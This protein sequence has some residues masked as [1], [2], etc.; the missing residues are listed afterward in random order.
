MYKTTEHIFVIRF[1]D[2]TTLDEVINYG[3]VI[4][5]QK[6]MVLNYDHLNILADTTL[7]LSDVVGEIKSVQGYGLKNT[8]IVSPVLIRFLI[9]PGIQVYLSLLDDAAAV[10]K[11]LLNSGDGIRSVMVVTSL[12]P[13]KIGDHLHLSSTA[14]TKFYFGNKLPAIADF[15]KSF[16]GAETED[17]PNLNAETV[18]TSKQLSSVGDLNM[19]LSNSTGQD[20]YFACK[21]RIVEVV[22][23]NGWY[24]V[25][26]TRCGKKFEKTATS[27]ACNQCDNPNATGVVRLD[28]KNHCEFIIL[29]SVERFSKMSSSMLSS[30]NQPST[31]SASVDLPSSLSLIPKYLKVTCASTPRQQRRFIT[32]PAFKPSQSLQ[33][34]LTGGSLPVTKKKGEQVFSG[35]TCK[36][37]E[38]EAI[39][40]ATGSR[41]FFGKIARLVDRTDQWAWNF[42][43]SSG[44]GGRPGFLLVEGARLC[45]ASRRVKN[46]SQSRE[47]GGAPLVRHAAQLSDLEL[48]L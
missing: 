7:E 24:S 39:V 38:V 13:E 43:H 1:I 3:P 22:S 31:L 19:F 46:W 10:F 36:Q 2:Q 9:A 25:S 34:V 47:A 26:C 35:S 28:V 14:A 37:G 42:F 44:S 17:L 41:T 4:N 15:T 11:G 12:N 40:I 18:I 20:I 5:D 48:G 23:K 6:F 8:R 27:L 21:A 16:R 33:P 30:R 29:L 45:S 32:T